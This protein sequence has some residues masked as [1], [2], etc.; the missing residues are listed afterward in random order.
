MWQMIFFLWLIPAALVFVAARRVADGR[1]VVT[2]KELRFVFGGSRRAGLS[3]VFWLA[4]SVMAIGFFVL[5]LV[6][7][8]VLLNR[9]VLWVMIAPLFTAGLATLLLILLMRSR[10]S[11]RRPRRSLRQP[12]PRKSMKYSPDF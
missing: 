2:A 6:Q 11:Y 1:R 5:G 8:V 9:G 4:I 3:L 12:A 7:A 10:F